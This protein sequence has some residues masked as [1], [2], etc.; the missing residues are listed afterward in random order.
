MSDIQTIIQKTKLF[1]RH[2]FFVGILVLRR[3]KCAIIDID[4]ERISTA[5]W[6][7]MK[8]SKWYILFLWSQA[9]IW[10]L[11][12]SDIFKTVAAINV[13]SS[14]FILTG[15]S[16]QKQNFE[17]LNDTFYRDFNWDQNDTRFNVLAQLWETV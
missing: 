10:Y 5:R 11:R 7:E 3:Y 15:R 16:F 14:N 9:F 4:F 17:K 6:V 2:P 1:I 13:W 12:L 8:K